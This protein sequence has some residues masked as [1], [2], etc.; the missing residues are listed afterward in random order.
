MLKSNPNIDLSELHSTDIFFKISEN[1][2]IFVENKRTNETNELSIKEKGW[3]KVIS[4][5]LFEQ[6]T[7]QI[8]AIG[9]K[10]SHKGQLLIEYLLEPKYRSSDRK[11]IVS[12]EKLGVLKQ[13]Y[14]LR[15]AWLV[16]SLPY[17]HSLQNWETLY[18]DNST[19]DVQVYYKGKIFAAAK[20]YK[21]TYEFFILKDEY[22]AICLG[23]VLAA[24]D[25]KDNRYDKI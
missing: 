10:R 12:G 13:C 23:L 21:G 24:I 22:T 2:S 18:Y 25:A 7:V 16:R 9:K 19:K 11:I 20:H 3:R 5:T 14:G 17:H 6:I 15:S 1:A 4:G 8:E